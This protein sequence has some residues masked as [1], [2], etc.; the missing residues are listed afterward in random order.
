MKYNSYN[1]TSNWDLFQW[2][3]NLITCGADNVLIVIDG[4]P[5]V[6]Y[7]IIADRFKILE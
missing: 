1:S 2:N 3:Q 7:I 4:T 6:S 5:Q